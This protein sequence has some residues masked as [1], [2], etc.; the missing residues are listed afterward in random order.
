MR[1][2]TNSASHLEQI[3]GIEDAPFF[4][5]GRLATRP[6]DPSIAPVLPASTY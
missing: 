3:A 4:L 6:T 2:K 5:C 1:K